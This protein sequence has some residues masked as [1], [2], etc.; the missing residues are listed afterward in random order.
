M[1]R[2][3]AFLAAL[4][5][6]VPAAAQSPRAAYDELIAAERALSDAAAQLS[7][8]EGI[9]SMLAGDVVFMSRQG[10]IRGRPAALANLRDNPANSGTHA[11]WHSIRGGVSADG[12]HGFTLGYLDIARGDP[13]RAHR[14][15]LAYWVR[16]A[17]GWRVAVFKQVLRPADEALT[18]AQPAALPARLIRADAALAA[19]HNATLIAAERAFSDRAQ[20]VGIHRSFQEYGRPDAIHVF[21]PGFA[22]GLAAIGAAQAAQPGSAEPATINWSA[23]SA[24]TASSG[25]L[26]VTI[27]MIRSNGA[28]PAGQPA[29]SPFFTIWA[30]DSADQPWRYIAE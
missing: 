2:I 8:A 4:L 13:A 12:L 6:A 1:T 16:G 25:D 14:R 28:P 19:G 17:E 30:R 10:A 9:A 29:A 27:G 26:G 22:I 3:L 18:Q 23:D 7:P 5:F 21:A 24:I 15:Y 20:Q 11:R